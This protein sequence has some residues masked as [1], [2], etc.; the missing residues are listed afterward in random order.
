M[1]ISQRDDV[2]GSHV[3][4]LRNARESLQLFLLLQF[5]I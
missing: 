3:A 5:L 2:A 4:D 1:P